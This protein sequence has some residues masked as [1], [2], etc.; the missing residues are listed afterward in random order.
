MLVGFRVKYFSFGDRNKEA[1]QNIENT[2]EK[3]Q[4]GSYPE[5]LRS[6]LYGMIMLKSVL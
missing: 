3:P 5:N 6:L 4:L 1:G 2:L